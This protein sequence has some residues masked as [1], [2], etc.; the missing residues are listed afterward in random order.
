MSGETKPGTNE[1]AAE[2]DEKSHAASIKEAIDNQRVKPTIRVALLF[3]FSNIKGPEEL[4]LL[5]D[6]A[7]LVSLSSQ[8]VIIPIEIIQEA[9]KALGLFVEYATRRNH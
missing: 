3:A 5:A 4:K 6:I 7:H 1:K 2:G 8:Y 9:E